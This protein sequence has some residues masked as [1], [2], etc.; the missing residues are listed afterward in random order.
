MTDNNRTAALT[1]TIDQADGNTSVTAQ[2]EAGDTKIR[3]DE[4]LAMII[5]AVAGDATSSALDDPKFL[6]PNKE[7]GHDGLQ[8]D[9]ARALLARVVNAIDGSMAA[10]A[11]PTVLPTPEQC[12]S[13]VVLAM[14]EGPERDQAMEELKDVIRSQ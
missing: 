11:E 10:D 7:R 2:Y 14:P 4:A 13:Q 1:V 8:V 5:W 6:D 3:I 9:M 12:L